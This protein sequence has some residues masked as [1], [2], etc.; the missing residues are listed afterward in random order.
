MAADTKRR[1]LHHAK[2][3]LGSGAAKI[4]AIGAKVK[5]ASKRRRK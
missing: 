2:G 4:P 3:Q 5:R 1:V